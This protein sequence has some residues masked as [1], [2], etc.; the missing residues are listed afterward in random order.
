MEKII[1]TTWTLENRDMRKLSRW[2]RCLFQMT[3]H[4]NQTMALKC[5]DNAQ[6]IAK[7]AQK[8]PVSNR[9]REMLLSLMTNRATV[10]SLSQG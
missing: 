7:R 6:A 1:N 5:L 4:I 2:I 3:L 8:D 10:K 9:P